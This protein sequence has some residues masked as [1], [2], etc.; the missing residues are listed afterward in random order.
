MWFR[1]QE[2]FVPME[3]NADRLVNPR[4]EDVRAKQLA[5]RQERSDSGK[6]GA[7]Q[8]W[9]EDSLANGSA[10]KQPLA[11]NS[12]PSPSSSPSLSLDKEGEL[13]PLAISSP[14][15]RY[16]PSFQLFWSTSTKR[17][18]KVEAFKEWQK[19]RVD[20]DSIAAINRGMDDWKH[21]EQWQDETKQ[22]HI[23]R[24]LKRRGWEEEVP[25]SRFNGSGN[26]HTPKPETTEAEREE[27]RKYWADMGFKRK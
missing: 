26:G 11:K 20:G 12:S 9:S 10:I 4:Q 5:Y 19:L 3:G 17:G 6:R 14:E 18:S 25:K 24:W 23:C 15:Q 27:A 8:R 13:K 7:A 1:L 16:A 22:P 21:S 2:C